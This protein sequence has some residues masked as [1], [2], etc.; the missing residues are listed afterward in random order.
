MRE[1]ERG[2]NSEGGEREGGI[3][4]YSHINICLPKFLK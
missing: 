3:T 1:G 2:R 4:E